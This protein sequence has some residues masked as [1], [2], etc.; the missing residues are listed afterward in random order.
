MS[1][2]ITLSLV[3]GCLVLA[4]VNIVF[5][6]FIAHQPPLGILMLPIAWYWWKEF[7]GR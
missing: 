3:I 1:R 5:V 6:G 2:K 7:K 4:I